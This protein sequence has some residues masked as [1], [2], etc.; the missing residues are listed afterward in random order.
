MSKFQILLTIFEYLS[1]EDIKNASLT[2]KSWFSAAMHSSVMD[3]RVLCIKR[4]K[5]YNYIKNKYF[6]GG[7]VK[8]ILSNNSLKIE[9]D[10]RC[11]KLN[12]EFQKNQTLKYIFN[13][14]N[15]FENINSLDIKLTNDL[16]YKNLKCLIDSS[17]MT[18]K[19]YIQLKAIKILRLTMDGPEMICY[20]SFFLDSM[21]ELQHIHIKMDKQLC[22]CCTKKLEDYLVEGK[23]RIKTLILD[24]RIFESQKLISAVQGMNLTTMALLNNNV[25][26][27]VS[28]S[29]PRKLRHLRFPRHYVSDNIDL[30]CETYSNVETLTVRGV[31]DLKGIKNLT[32]LKVN[33]GL[34]MIQALKSLVYSSHL[35]L[36]LTVYFLR[37]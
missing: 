34:S 28:F 29:E 35:I 37:I 27:H 9:L 1:V 5:V 14:L 24:A 25:S 8:P 26:S 15:Q 31:S 36:F 20:L 23:Q 21:P 33:C 6:R 17:T 12:F 2:C 7:V 32:K 30:I 22:S 4:K 18:D 3:R 19:S 10:C 16:V 13:Y 11:N